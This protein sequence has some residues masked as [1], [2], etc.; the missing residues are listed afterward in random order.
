MCGILFGEKCV[1]AA[2]CDPLQ[3]EIMTLIGGQ[4]EQVKAEHMAQ[5]DQQ[6]VTSTNLQ[7]Q[8]CA[9]IS[10]GYLL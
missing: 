6:G 4:G 1:W 10:A 7:T 8:P 9:Y 5:G 3:S 2:V